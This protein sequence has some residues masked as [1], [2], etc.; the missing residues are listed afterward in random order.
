MST[1]KFLNFLISNHHCTIT[2]P[3][4]TIRAAAAPGQTHTRNPTAG[5]RATTTAGYELG[6]TQTP[7]NPHAAKGPR[8]FIEQYARQYGAGKPKTC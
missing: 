5:G 4:G 3:S 8:R 6:P 1:H 2:A 7:P